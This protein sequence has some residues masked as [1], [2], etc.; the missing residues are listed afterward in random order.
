MTNPIVLTSNK[1]PKKVNLVSPLE[2]P[3]K[4]YP[5]GTRSSDP[6][7]YLVDTGKLIDPVFKTLNTNNK[8]EII[9]PKAKR[10]LVPNCSGIKLSGIKNKGIRNPT[11]NKTR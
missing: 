10:R 3:D 6:R 11:A 9:T 4:K 7:K 8:T 1:Y 5:N 2:S